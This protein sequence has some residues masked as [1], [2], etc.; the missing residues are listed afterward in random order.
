MVETRRSIEVCPS[1]VRSLD[2][3][4]LREA[5]L[6]DAHVGHDLEAAD[7]GG[8]K[9][10]RRVGH[11][12]E[13]AI[14]AV[15]EAQALLQRLEM[16]ITGAQA[17]RL[18]NHEIDQANDVGIVARFRLGAVALDFLAVLD[19][20]L[21]AAVGADQRMDHF[22]RAAVVALEGQLDLLGGSNDE[23]DVE[24][25]LLAQ[26]VDGVEVK[27]VRDGDAKMAPFQ[28]KRH[29]RQTISELAGDGLDRFLRHGI[30]FLKEIDPSLGGGRFQNV[31]VGHKTGADQFINGTMSIFAG[32]ATG[33]LHIGR[34]DQAVLDQELQNKIVVGGHSFPF[35]V[36][37]PLK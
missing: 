21:V 1:A 9:L 29:D 19:L 35:Y 23:V 34:L 7:H 20:K 8:L 14:D 25:E 3:A 2:A 24:A 17:M 11:H 4:V 37:W 36:Y 30:D 32:L 28:M 18:E 13:H 22:A 27:G 12:L 6:R 16:D 10:L 31:E 33:V 26:G 15:T 5:L